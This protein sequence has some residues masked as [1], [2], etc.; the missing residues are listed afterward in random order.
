M[1]RIDGQWIFSATDLNNF[2]ECRRLPELELLVALGKRARP[3][4][5]DE[6][7]ELI[8]KK[9]EQ[10]EERYL[11]Q[12]RSEHGEAHLVSIPR[13]ERDL[14]AYL[15]AAEQTEA[16]MRAG[17]RVI[18]QA[19]FIDAAAREGAWIGHAD[20]LI[21]IESPSPAFGA[22][23]YQAVDTKLALTTKPYFIIQLCNY[24]EHL[25]RIQ[26]VVPECGRIV[27]GDGKQQAFK[28]NDYFAY[29]R[30]VKSRFLRTIPGDAA[31]Q[32]VEPRAYPLKND[33][34]AVCA[35]DEECEGQRRADD[36]LSLVARMRRDQ[37]MK[38]QAN[39]IARVD[40]L[41]AAGDDTRPTA[42]HPESFEKLRRQ[43]RLQVRSRET[44]EPLIE[45]LEHD[46]RAGFGLLPPPAPGDVYFDMEGDPVY[47]PGRGLEYLFGAYVH[48]EA[49]DEY[50]AFWGRDRAEEK[51]AFEA[52]V[53]LIVERRR[54]FPD[55]HVYHYANYEKAALQRL[56]Q[57]HSTR[58]QEVDDL[59]RG[60][61]LV[62]LFAVVRQT[63]LVGEERYS[64]KNLERFYGMKRATA[65][66][67]GDQS[68]VEFE[69]WRLSGDQAILDDIEAYNRDDCISTWL[70]HR[71]LLMQREHAA[72]RFGEIPFRPK[73]E[74]TAPCHEPPFDGCGKCKLRLKA[75]RDDAKRDDLER[76]LLR[77]V[78]DPQSDDEFY[79]MGEPMRSR[80][81]L[82]HAL[83][84]HRRESNPGW[85]AFFNRCENRDELLERDNDALGGL[86]LEG[87]G[88]KIGKDRN[89]TYTYRF[90]EQIHKMD[91]GRAAD[92]ATRE[93]GVIVAIDNDRR[94]VRFKFPGDLAAARRLTALIPDG[95]PD[96]S[97][98]QG[99]LGRAAHAYRDG[100]L[101][102]RYRATA[103]VLACTSPRM[104][105]GVP[106]GQP[107]SLTG[108][109]ISELV[110]SLDSSYLF[111]Q[112][113]PGTGKTTIGSEVICNLL[114][115]RMRVGVMSNSHKAAQHLLQ[116]VERCMQRRGERFRG[117][118]KHSDDASRYESPLA[119]PFIRST[120][121]NQDFLGE[122]YQL[123]GGTAWLFSREELEQKF[124][125]LFI[126]EAGQVSFANALAVS[127]CAKNIVLLG[128]P[129]QLAQVS[130]GS[131]APHGDDSVLKHLLGREA[132]VQPDRG[133]FLNESYRMHPE[134]CAFISEM[135]YDGR[136]RAAPNTSTHSV[137][138][139][140]L[141][142]GGLRYIPVEHE[143]NGSC[144]LE[145]ADRI[146]AEV[147][148]L[149]E[150]TVTD[151]D[152]V[153]KPL[154]DRDV[155]VVTPYNAQRRLISSRLRAAGYDIRVGTVDKFQG[156][157]ASVVFYSM[158]TSN[159]EEVPRDLA[160]LL[161]PNRM[162]VAL[163]RA[164]S[165]AVLLSSPL[166]LNAVCG[167]AAEI[168]SLNMLCS[169][170]EAATTQA[171]TGRAAVLRP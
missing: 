65:V 58:G 86:V 28:L 162:N 17:K 36:H 120:G 18:Y 19:T 46:P 53:D 34:C 160:F 33:H 105:S 3:S 77:G 32:I 111:I 142:G 64:I 95:P 115:Q 129:S 71:W 70:L 164:R 59:L 63:M 79:A 124:D 12:L 35:W 10:H 81:L 14:R 80:Y 134:I 112:G 7:A 57:Q 9:G 50:F 106:F 167:N 155:I 130:Q 126:D 8:R 153:A 116:E 26:G 117:L 44:G 144:S 24:S 100:R 83:S 98:L 123:A 165:I 69:K 170:V 119:A 52:F 68:I 152:G 72:A 2:L 171:G 6:Q 89:V 169:Y 41:A 101:G 23:G 166:L 150:G 87:E 11:E 40:S 5:E 161:E 159:G 133:I 84:Y 55:L 30:H 137:R 118:Y 104:L 60:E 75:E 94:I 156:Q 125:Y 108:S 29:Y 107:R 122:D 91:V 96:A 27:F 151:D 56:S 73:K 45:L 88:V 158:A 54:C 127:L 128:D 109:A 16:A 42:M 1:Q 37:M 102:E 135:M 15:H 39:G 13:P 146:V 110:R 82:G 49:P 138:S 154:C 132:T 90:P 163:S 147:A 25:A 139:P 74:A 141:A 168:A 67:K 99:A 131:H 48:G 4:I 78:M 22:Y 61:V 97:V 76:E 62:D 20:F 93:R 149:R 113:P 103:D 157:Q 140:G 43:A 143:G 92:P 145:E 31:S 38:L 51:R 114:Q 66:K 47:E 21:R 136:L 121:N 85:W 148:L